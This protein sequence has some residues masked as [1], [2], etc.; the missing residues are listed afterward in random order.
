MMVPVVPMLET[1]WVIA[2]F[3]VAPDFGTGGFVVGRRVVRVGEL[4]EDLAPAFPLHPLGQ[5]PGALHAGFPA[6]QHQLG[7]VGLHGLAP[8]DGQVL[9]HDQHHAV[10]ADGGG[11]GQGDAGVAA[12]GLDQGVAGPD[13]APGL[14]LGDHGQGR[15]VLHR[16]GRIVALQLHQDHVGG[17]ARK[18]LQTDQGSVADEVFD[19][20]VH[21]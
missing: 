16:A 8:L 3:G 15:P 14:G 6:H 12:G 13:L 20:F 1:K 9:G 4:V 10:A 11:H 5:V 19:G 7:A 17:F 18:L 21:G 2:A